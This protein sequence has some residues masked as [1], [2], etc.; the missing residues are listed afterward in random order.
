MVALARMYGQRALRVA[1]LILPDPMQ[2]EDAVQTAFLRA[3]QHRK[4][5]RPDATFW[6]WFRRLVV[7]EALRLAHRKGR[8]HPL[9][10]RDP[11]PAVDPLEQLEGE[12]RVQ[13]SARTLECLSPMQ[14]A[15]LIPRC[16]EALSEEKI[17]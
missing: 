17:T 9:E 6:P 16:Y 11:E 15:V 7:N 10:G 3:W 5:F 13:R 14:R 8:E 2:A 1:A 4:T 12:D